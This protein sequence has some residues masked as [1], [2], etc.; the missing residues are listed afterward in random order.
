MVRW[1]T[2]TPQALGCHRQTGKQKAR[3]GMSLP[4][5]YLLH[6]LLIQPV[7]PAFALY[8]ALLRQTSHLG[9]RHVSS[10]Q[11]DQLRT[12]ITNRFRAPR[13]KGIS[14]AF[15]LRAGYTALHILDQAVLGNRLALAQVKDI[16]QHTP[17]H[18]KAPQEPV[19]KPERERETHPPEGWRIL[20][21]G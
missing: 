3:E 1:F 12:I 17:A 10:S 21:R 6:N 13:A 18:I 15:A 4:S 19:A 9:P 20:D 8:R 16:L 11:C 7:L 14:R 2:N 5:Y